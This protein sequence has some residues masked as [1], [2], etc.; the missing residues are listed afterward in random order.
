MA[1]VPPAVGLDLIE[2]P[3]ATMLEFAGFTEP[4]VEKIRADGFD[5][6]DDLG[7]DV[8]EAE[9]I[10]DLSVTLG[11][12]PAN[13]GRVNFGI[14]RTKR[15]IG[16]M[17]WVQDHERVSLTANVVVGTTAV[18]MRGMWSRALE[19]ANARKA[20][21]KQSKATQTGA[22]PGELKSDKGFYDWDEKWENYLST[23]P[24]Q[25]GIPLSYVTRI[26]SAHI[27]KPD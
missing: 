18:N 11:R 25:N 8:L 17:H 16:M 6:L 26:D 5:Q 24:G 10:K 4:Q 21:E 12:L 13:G 22:D 23:I 2:D 1:F 19:R 15:L 9:D 14:A 27:Y 7:L 20:V 3:L